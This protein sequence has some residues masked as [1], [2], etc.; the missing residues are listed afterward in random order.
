MLKTC[1]HSRTEAAKIHLKRDLAPAQALFSYGL[2]SRFAVLLGASIF[3]A[4]TA[5][6]ET[7]TAEELLQLSGISMHLGI[8]ADAIAEEGYAMYAECLNPTDEGAEYLES[9]S[10]DKDAFTVLIKRHFGQSQS[11]AR[12]VEAMA[13]SMSDDHMA[14]TER[15]FATEVGQKIVKAETDSKHLSE[16][17]FV[18]TLNEYV[19]SDEWTA[20]RKQTIA[21]IS[22]A[23]RAVRFVSLINGEMSVAAKVSSACDAT[24]AGYLQLNHELKRERTDAR[25]VEPMMVGG[26]NLV[27][28]TI[29]KDLS[30]Q[31]INDY[32][33]FAQ[34]DAGSSYFNGLLQATRRGISG[35]LIGVREERIANY[36]GE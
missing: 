14:A 30:D 24:E 29:F 31:E 10:Y 2:S 33:T 3:S 5:Y 17:E 32:L 16:D 13:V 8:A 27:I 22:Q 25:F 7:D 4:G 28:A 20:S 9:V 1:L 12:A 26:L 6:A 18:T 36:E 23:T 11:F 34:S 19:S 35:G 15:F 21:Q